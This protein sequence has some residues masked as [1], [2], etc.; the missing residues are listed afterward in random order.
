MSSAATSSIGWSCYRRLLPFPR[1]L[2]LPPDPAEIG[3]MIRQ[4]ALEAGLRF[5]VDAH[6]T[7]WTSAF[8]RPPRANAAHYPSCRSHLAHFKAPRTAM[9]GPLPKTSTG[10]IQK[11]VLRE[12]A[13][14]NV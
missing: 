9:F 12:R 4:P 10:K 3:Q 6:G 14:A 5:E 2:L 8:V 11:F 13:K 7:G 1:F